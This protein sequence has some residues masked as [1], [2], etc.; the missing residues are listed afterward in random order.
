MSYAKQPDTRLRRVL[1]LRD[2]VVYGIVLISPLAPVGVF[3]VAAKMARG[4]VMTAILLGMIAMILTA[5]SYGR[6]AGVYPAAGSAYAYVSRGLNPY[7]GFLAGWA[8]FLDYLIIP[9][10]NVTYVALTAHRLLPEIPFSICAF[11]VAALITALNLR[12]VRMTA[13][14]NEIL[15]ACM[16]VIV[17]MFVVLS[18]RFLLQSGGLLSIQPLYDARTFNIRDLGTATSLVA[19]TYIGFDGVT[20]LAEETIDAKRTV[21]LATVL[22]CLLTGLLSTL[23]TYLAQRVWPDYNSFTN[24]ET[25]FLDVSR[26]VGGTFLFNAMGIVLVIASFGSGLGG[27]AGAARLLYGMGRDSVLPQRIFGRL[28]RRTDTPFWNVL[29]LGVLAFAGSMLLPWEQSAEMLN[30]GAF[31]SFMG[32]N[33]AVLRL[34]YGSRAKL[35]IGALVPF[36]GFVFCLI[37]FLSLP[38]PAKIMGGT[39]LLAGLIYL[40]LFTHNFRKGLSALP[41]EETS[42]E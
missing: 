3:G 29:F 1:S 20:T 19:L 31:L 11:A 37:I 27:Q 42:H 14:V 13:R 22:V 5:S 32:V 2:L 28:A 24:P 7:L 35:S 39:W 26:R 16:F 21:P 25:A 4:H 17:A 30:F 10:L 15:L 9:I 18:I 12:S 41:F 34:F 38:V 6:M 40:V 36:G 23:E 8:M 33:L